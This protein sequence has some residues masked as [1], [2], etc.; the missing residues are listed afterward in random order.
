M[1]G[2][3]IRFVVRVFQVLVGRCLPVSRNNDPL[4]TG[5]QKSMMF[6]M[7]FQYCFCGKVTILTRRQEQPLQVII[8]LPPFKSLLANLCSS[9]NTQQLPFIFRLRALISLMADQS[10]DLLA[11]S[12]NET[13]DISTKHYGQAELCSTCHAIDWEALLLVK[14]DSQKEIYYDL[15]LVELE[16]TSCPCCL[17]FDQIT[18]MVEDFY[19]SQRV[20][21]MASEGRLNIGNY[22]YNYDDEDAKY[23]DG[24]L[25]SESEMILQHQ[26]YS[27][28]SNQ[29]LEVMFRHYCM[30]DEFCSTTPPSWDTIG[31][32]WQGPASRKLEPNFID[33]DIIREWIEYC[34][35]NHP[36]C[37][38]PLVV[39]LKLVNCQTRSI[40]YPLHH[41]PYCA[42]SYVW[43]SLKSGHN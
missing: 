18:N 14:D 34:E 10:T 22:D 43:G 33:F 29:Y 11:T 6:L 13:S 24:V 42:L 36:Q 21:I 2:N 32:S 39:P 20:M 12:S 35:Q 38:P 7:D 3:L 26:I 17:F 8:R 19:P 15:G 31:K 5:F 4:I 27:I 9:V 1:C 40:E 25:K 37:K 41:Q 28:L 16:H 30:S 23:S